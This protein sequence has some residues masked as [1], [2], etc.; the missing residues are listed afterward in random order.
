MISY[1]VD[2]HGNITSNKK[3]KK[4]KVDYVVGASGKVTKVAA[5]EES[6]SKPKTTT[7]VK[8][9]EDQKWYEGWFKSGSFADNKEGAPVMEYVSDAFESTLATIG[10][11]SVGLV[12]GALS[13]VEG[14]KD[15][16]QYGVAG[17]ADLVGADKFAEQQ[18]A[19]AQASDMDALFGGLQDYFG[20]SSFLGDRGQQ[21]PEVLGNLALMYGTAG[22]GSAAGLGSTG[23]T[24]LITGTTA[25]GSMGSGMS[26]AY[27]AGATDV[28]AVTY[29]AIKG[30]ADAGTELIFGGLGKSINALGYGVGLS[31]AD[32]MLA[33]KVSSK[34]SNQLAK[35]FVEYGI[36][37]GAE[38]TEEVMAGFLSALGKK[39]TYMSEEELGSLIEDEKLLDQFI[40][41]TF[42]SAVGQSGYVP[43]MKQGSLREAN[44]TGRDF[45]TG[46]TQN[47]QSVVDRIVEDRIKEAEEGGEK[48]SSKEKN[49]IKKDAMTALEKGYIDIDTI[50][51]VL[52]GETYNT[53]KSVSEQEETLQ[54]EYDTLN[55]MKQGEMT[56]EQI[57][58]RTELKQQLAELKENSKKTQLKEQLSKEVSEMALSD[59]LGESYREQARRSQVFEADLSK[60]DAKQQEIVK[61]AAE[62]GILNNTNRTHDFVDMLAKLSAGKGV[63][64]DFTS[65]QKLKE[66]GF[67]LEGK[68]INGFVKD[69]NITLNIDSAK[70]LNSV[71][72][73]EI[74]H[75]LEGTEL[76][77]ELQNVLKQYATTKG[78]YDTR[79][80][81]LAKLY[82]GVEGA[83]IEAELTADLVGDYLFTDSEFVS[84][85]STEKP[86]LFKRIYE[87]IKYM[88]KVATAGSKELRELEKAKR[89]FEKAWQNAEVSS[90]TSELSD[91]DVKYS[92]R[93]EA[94]PKETGIAYKVFYVKDGKLYPPMV[95]NPNGADTPMG[96]WLNADVGTAAPPSK[97]GRQQVKAGGKG[98]QGGSGSL[99]F[100]PGWHLGDLPR[101]SQ[102]DR[103][104]PETGKKELFPENFVWAEVEYAKDVD[105]QEEAMSYGY[106]DNGKFR[107]AYAGLPRLPE[108]GYYRYRTNPKPDTVPWVITGAMKVNRLLSDAEVNKILEENGVE[109]VHRQ[110]GDV[111]LDK[112]GF[113]NDGTIKYS[114]TETDKLYLDA[115]EKHD[116]ETMQ[117][118]VDEAAK[119][120]GYGIKA[121]HGTGHEFTVFDKSKQGSNYEDWGR[122]G[123]GFYFAPNAKDAKIWA[124][125]SRGD[126]TKVMPVYL[127]GDNM[128]DVFGALPDDL[129]NTIPQDWDSLT[130]R[131]AEKYAYNYIE[132]MQEFGYD[133]QEILTSNGYDGIKDKGTEYVVFDPE[134]VKSADAIT[135]DDAGEIIP[136][137][138]RFKND[139]LDIRYS[140]T[141]S[142][143][144]QLSKEQQEYF[145]DS[146]MRD[147]NGNLKV[148]YHGTEDG[149][150]HEF[151]PRFA[152]Y[153]AGMFFVDDNVVAKSYSGTHETYSAKTLNTVEDLNNFFA[154]IDATEY[155][156]V[157]EDGKY[158]LYE[159]GDEIAVSDTVP[160]LFE[161][162][163]DWTGNGYGGVNYKVYLNLKNPLI[164][165]AQNN[166]WDEVSSEFS[167]ELYDRYNALTEDEK[168]ALVDVAEWDDIGIFRDELQRAK[169]DSQDEHYRNLAS[170]YE[171]LGGEDIDFYG[172]FDVAL[173]GFTDESIKNNAVKNLKT[174][175]YAH[176][177][178]EQGCDGVIFNNIVDNGMFASGI[179]RLTSS[180]VAIAFDSNQIK[181]VDNAN[182]T[183][184]PDI[185]FS[186]SEDSEGRPLSEGQKSYFADSK[187]VDKNGHLKVMYHGTANDFT[188]FNP[189]LQGG[190]NGTAEGY[191]IYFADVAQVTESYGDKRMTGYLNITHPAR[192][193][194]KTIKKGELVKLLKATTEI[195]AKQFVAD[196]DYD[197]VKDA[198]KDTWISNYVDTYSTTMNEAYRE[199]AESILS[200]NENDMH[201]IQEVMGGMAIR[202][203]ESAYRFYDVLKSTLGIDG[204][205]TE[206]ESD[207]L[208][209]GKAQIAVAFD[210][211]QFK[212]LDNV[213]PTK[214]EDVRHSLSESNRGIAPVGNYNVYGKDIALETAPTEEVA[215]PTT[216]ETKKPFAEDY[217]PLN[218]VDAYIRDA[219]TENEHYFPDD[220]AP[221]AEEIYDGS[222]AEHHE[223]PD[224][225]YERDI[226]DIGK[227]R[228]TKAYMY[229]NPEV[230]PFFQEEAN[231]MLGEL[232]NSTKGERGYNDQ[233]YYD[234]NGEMGFFGTTRNTSE[235]IA[236][237]LDTFNYTHKDIEK[238]LRAII[239][240]NGKEN[241]AISKRI[242][243]LIDERLRKGYTHFIFGDKIPPNQEYINTLIEKQVTE[244][245]DES[246]NNWLQNLSEDD[247]NQ[248]FRASD[249]VAPVENPQEY[250]PIESAPIANDATPTAEHEAIKPE[251]SKGPRMAKVKETEVE[252]IAKILDTEPVTKSQRNKRKWAIFKANVLDKG[253]VFEDLSL[254]KKNRELMGKWNYTL[255]SE[256][257]AQRLMGNGA[258][259]VKALNDIRAEVES[260]GL[261]K[262]FYE[263]MYHK[264]NAD[265]MNL[266]GRY[267]G[268]E[269][270]PVF[271]YSVTKEVSQ[272]IIDQYEASHPEFKDYANDVYDYMNYLR[273]QLVDNGVISQ[274]TADLWAE[275]YPHYVPIRRVDSKGLNIDVP[276]DT[277][278]TG[279]NA[280]IKRARGGN[281]DILPLF[282]TM[283]SRTIQ[284]Y[285]ATAKNSFGVELK[286]TLGSVI[287]NTATN[288]DEVIDSIDTQE[289]L[290]QEGKNGNLPTFTVFENGEKVTFEITEDMYDALKPVSS[291]SM[292]SKTIKPLNV[293]SNIHR[294]LLTEYNPVFMLTNA[295]KDSQDILINSQH[296]AKTYLKVP[297]ANVQLLT[298]GYWYNEYMSHGGEQN[299]YF[300]NETNTFKTENKGIAK[301]LD[302]PPFSTI[303]SINNQI[304][305]IPRLAEYIASREA[306]RSIEVSMLDAARV[307]TNFRAGGD[308]TKF[309]NRNGATFLNASVQ[310]AMQNVRNI[311]EAKANGLKGMANLVTKFAL[312]GLPAILLNNLVWDDDE[313]YEELSDYVKQ[314]Y[315]VVWKNDDGKFIRIPKG[316]TLAVIQEG[317]QQISNLATGNDE[318]DLNSFL[319]L[320]VNNLAPNN[321][322]DN[323]I[324][325]P[326]IQVANNETWYGEDLVPSRL[327]DLPANEQF[328]ESTD[329]FSKWLG[330]KLDISP[331]KINY[332]LDQ[333]TGGVGDVVLPMLTPEAESGDDSVLGN[334]LAP[335]KGKFSTDSVMNNQNVTDFYET[336]D[337]LTT[338]AKKSDAT[339][340]DVLKNKYFNAIKSE[341]GEL[342]AEKREVQNDGS[343][344]NSEKYYLVKETQKKIDALAKEA[345]NEYPDVYI[346]GAYS[347]IGDKQ[348]RKSED[349]WEKITDKQLEKQEEV[350]KGLGITPGEYWGN[351]EEYDYQYE[352]PEKYD[353]L[354]ESGVSVSEYYD[355]DEETKEAYTWAFKNPEKRKMSQVIAGDYVQYRKISSELYDIK[356]DKDGNGE[357]IS[358]SAKAKKSAYINSLD[359]DYGQ[360]IILFR[361]LYD[362]KTDKATYNA[363]IVE[364][365][366]SRD[367]VSYDEMITILEALDMKV[368]SDG[369]VVW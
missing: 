244:Y 132:Y 164:V 276:L 6:V 294:G 226:F 229:E 175:D 241:N 34:I 85:L 339:E 107:H 357:S 314:N 123:K 193:D 147:E 342:Y 310:G 335:L 315:Y 41:G 158:V 150:F 108:N 97:T 202:D 116:I 42:A 121:Y 26:E 299:S 20:K 69:G 239:E 1:F 336:S 330:E 270:K 184:N 161:E 186:L 143:G 162:Y 358:G 311:R 286:N 171:K 168:R 110:G 367:D 252:E 86:N 283:A 346:D 306:G 80:Q 77:P 215:E 288:V 225:F 133:I 206:W 172:L 59:R 227:D 71:V 245:N 256:S 250:A 159:D 18:K 278:R 14:I 160:G 180:T 331:V 199:C 12:K 333:Y 4:K 178:K 273:N 194:K 79:Y 188:V 366:N 354:K 312:A 201:I 163:R 223:V 55:Q 91:T 127:K 76:A 322:L 363:D 142:D 29:G 13:P 64:F 368:L 46:Y 112:F 303:S 96:V 104:N 7:T 212:N 350:T 138:E 141:D 44:Q 332:L 103:V 75:V 355:F 242:E 232:N 54:K 93:E 220:M 353:F 87:E 15:L 73:H 190:K 218:E 334:I 63:S 181:S 57:D 305:M 5:Q 182:P 234:T 195:E 258:E 304:E 153:D 165:D 251:P 169:A 219:K 89:L 295:I 216:A 156:A 230:K 207:L 130:K 307:T 35:N 316:R 269:N 341:L 92:I 179:D 157:V 185:R 146:K 136:L 284:T 53:Y 356:A 209:E 134:Q 74:M 70:A 200:M 364:Y 365:L 137:S 272:G 22:L 17:V 279:V 262:Q 28:E 292:L 173:E 204:Y 8:E 326:I 264:H 117:K 235:E 25:A 253:A 32:D 27:N 31:S 211:N 149:G 282:D 135:Y 122:L 351:K 88:C 338:N 40:L 267:D 113:S 101:A 296:P 148:M 291:S 261:T 210:S 313:E 24:A 329:T 274:E 263:Y 247:I 265:R 281:S 361:S 323:N 9:D 189:L 231:Y 290:L 246:W 197:N 271:G 170:V 10:D 11:A 100:R 21:A 222:Y 302:L 325:A 238:G 243:F 240:D 109:P 217:A 72:G 56:G 131:L 308:V 50:E 125:K 337:I 90:E 369:R 60:Y 139:S 176:M 285:K 309:L 140:L 124:E 359:L 65:N 254:K 187:I 266:E 61:K 321:P 33:Q 48:L 99:A 81:A 257:R 78:E 224:P 233:L 129:K 119:N 221:E 236:Y 343:L 82:E 192:A 151:N 47:E 196:G 324:L 287:E 183:S 144:K 43:G 319:E 318:A 320:M 49:A 68:T 30:V 66:S 167:Q 95:A 126:N 213:N 94:P 259:G 39:V 249:R 205:I 301:L 128:L 102:F 84:R 360:K 300:D 62:S 349:G 83:D 154:E 275:M 340:E 16:V 23:V 2:E 344:S 37:A 268:I 228:S 345:L 260:T 317:I 36:K 152:S 45:V 155:E 208:P 347:T 51:S 145:K 98:T 111:D 352:Y 58:R 166:N 280:P 198:L 289:G 114:L 191:G 105:Y 214:D 362:S 3:K 348:Y 177:A 293:A 19:E 255:Y 118:M 237:L 298:K 248:Y 297:E 115:V 106:T 328:D 52:G 120:A 277:R 174:R 67:A 203:Y 327:Q 38:G